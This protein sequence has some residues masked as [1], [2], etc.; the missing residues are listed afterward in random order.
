MSSDTE[1]N[2]KSLGFDLDG[3]DWDQYISHRPVYPLSFYDKLNTHHA[4]L[5]GNVFDLALDAGAG[6]GIV[7]EQLASKF[8]KVIVAEPNPE[9]LKDAQ[10]RLSSYPSSKFEFLLEKSE[11]LSVDSASVD[12][13]V[14]SMS[15]HWTDVPTAIN[16]FARLLKS[17]GTLYIVNYA[18]CT[19]LDNPKAN[20]IFREI[21][22]EFVDSFDTKPEPIKAVI[23]RA[24]NTL[25]CGFDNLSFDAHLWKNV[26]REFVNCE[27]DS[28]KLQPPASAAPDQGTYAVG[29]NDERVF[30][31]DDK[32]WV[33]EGCDIEWFKQTF[34]AYEFGGKVED[35][36]E[37][38]MEL[39]KSLGG[40][41]KKARVIWPSVHI[42]ATRK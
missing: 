22:T 20:A 28:T 30:V 2:E 4:S 10:H 42:F 40:R 33:T 41:N 32:T 15:I 12:L 34:M 8:N 39:E 16:E 18:L 38:W 29:D 1:D 23:H 6:P 11:Q 19:I 7:G 25:S 3:F 21:V 24:L 26:R 31:E 37:K 14:N 5:N 35:S 17:G 13:V 27:G 36:R 9:Y